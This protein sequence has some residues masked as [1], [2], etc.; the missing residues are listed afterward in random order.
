MAEDRRDLAECSTTTDVTRALSPFDAREVLSV[1]A[2]PSLKVVHDGVPPEDRLPR[3][4]PQRFRY[5]DGYTNLHGLAKWMSF[6]L[7]V[8]MGRIS[9]QDSGWMVALVRP[10]T[11]RILR[12]RSWPAPPPTVHDRSRSRLIR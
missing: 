6:Y 10:Q 3:D 8:V 4:E 12:I 7:Y 11:S 2:T 9:S 5:R 1:V